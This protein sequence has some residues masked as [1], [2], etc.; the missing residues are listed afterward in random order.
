MDTGRFHQWPVA[1]R[2]TVS[3]GFSVSDESW[4]VEPSLDTRRR[5]RLSTTRTGMAPRPEE[6][7][8]E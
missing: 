3:P 1:V 7:E 6:A 4:A 2:S 5:L 8:M